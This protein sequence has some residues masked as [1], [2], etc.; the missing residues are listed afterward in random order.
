MMAIMADAIPEST[1]TAARHGAQ[2]DRNQQKLF[3]NHGPTP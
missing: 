3:A 2:G 1:A